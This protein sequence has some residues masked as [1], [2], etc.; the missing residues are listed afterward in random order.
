MEIAKEHFEARNM[1]LI[2]TEC[3]ADFVKAA[4]MEYGTPEKLIEAN[5]VV[6]VMT[7][8]LRKKKQLPED[9]NSIAL[10]YEIMIAAGLVHNLFFDGKSFASLARTR[11]VLKPVAVECNVPDQY[12][13][14]IFEAVEAQLGEDSFNRN[15]VP[16]DNTP[17][18][19]FA[20]ANW[21]VKEFKPAG[22]Q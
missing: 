6:D 9:N 8:M 3:I 17:A 21:F 4:L 10:M 20:W 12:L 19:I 22:E 7:G 16:G 2:Q 18:G 5:K 14:T 13:D 11:D 15:L 1:K